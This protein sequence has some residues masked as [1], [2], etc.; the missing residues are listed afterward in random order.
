M[1]SPVRRAHKS[2]IAKFSVTPVKNMAI[3]LGNAQ[4]RKMAILV[5]GMIERA[6]ALT[7]VK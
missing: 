6:S 7:V 5:L 2:L 4:E 1:P 3:T